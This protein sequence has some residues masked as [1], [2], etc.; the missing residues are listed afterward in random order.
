MTRL[1]HPPHLLRNDLG[2]TAAAGP[3]VALLSLLHLS[4]AHVMDS[5][6]PARCEWIELLAHDPYWAGLLH[7]HRPYEAL[8]HWALAAH[9]ERLRRHPLAPWSQRAYD[10][11]LCTGDNIDN[12]QANELQAFVSILGG[13]RTALSAHGG[14]H[15]PGLELGEGAWPF[16][17]PEAGV[18][19]LWKPKGYPVVPGFV[20]RSSAEVHSAGLGFAWAS[21]PGN[22]DVMRQGTALPNPAIEALAVGGRKALAGPAGFRPID[23]QALYVQQPEQFSTGV[24]RPIAASA[25]RR[26]VDLCEWMAA[27]RQAGAMG[28]GPSHVTEGRA[29]TFIDTE[30]VRLILLDTNHPAGD[31]QGSIGAAQIAWLEARLAEVEQQPGRI[32]VLASHHGS[33]SLVNTLGADPE[34]LQGQALTEAVHRHP[35][36]VAW[37]VGHRHLHRVTPHPH[38]DARGRGFWEITTAS[39]MD[40]PA[41]TRAVEIL[42]HTDGQLEIVCTLQDHHAEAGSLAALHAELALRF[43]GSA[44]PYMQGAA[45]DGNVRLLL[46]P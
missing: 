29:D 15:E 20:A 24:S 38:P 34:R 33:V 11:A 21:V 45:H 32:A 26:A 44:A 35:C 7:M 14:V 30:H 43:A 27:H 8:T 46:P 6:S 25:Q 37:L 41:Q 12:A 42:R 13:G 31:Y 39:I 1:M 23:P 10:M 18:P 4:D 9:V 36:V 3:G 16:W 5:V 2:G 17:C 19:D 22:H 28:F 40:W